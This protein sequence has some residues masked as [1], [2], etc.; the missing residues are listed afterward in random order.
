MA[1]WAGPRAALMHP[2]TPDPSEKT[3]RRRPAQVTYRRAALLVAAALLLVLALCKLLSLA[4]GPHGIIGLSISTLDWLK[5]LGAWS[6]PMLFACEAVSF[7]LLGPI[8]PLHVGCGFLWGSGPGVLLAWAAYGVGCVPPFL[9]ARLP[10]LAERFKVLR[11]RVDYLDG[12]FS[13]VES[14]PFKLIVCLRLSPMLPSPLNSYLLGLTAV[15]LRT[16]VSASCVGTLPNVGAY[17]YLGSLLDSLADI[18]AGRVQRS[19]LSWALLITGLA[20]TVGM[21][22]YVSRVATRRVQAASRQRTLDL[23]ADAARL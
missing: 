3:T 12:V 7:L 19:P 9:L 2:Q 11:R 5:G 18:A 4:G 6:V 23:E 16:Y 15:P 13:A 21:L 8:W 22:L 17:V 10:C 14:E 20:A 1:L